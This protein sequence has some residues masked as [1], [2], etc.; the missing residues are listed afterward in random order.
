[1][2]PAQ[3]LS[4]DIPEDTASDDALADLRS[5]AGAAN[6]NEKTLLATDYLNHFNDF[7]MVLDLIPDMP[8]CLEDA[9]AWQ[10][11]NYQDHFRDSAFSAKQLAIEAYEHSPAEYRDQFES[12]VDMINAMI[13]KG[14]ERI[15]SAVDEGN[16]DR[17]GFECA[18][19]S[20]SLQKLMDLISA[21]INGEN[22]IIDQRGIDEMLEN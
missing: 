4:P 20:Q 12:L 19:T 8:D 3:N 7:V 22:P 13:P 10:P 6:I 17:I 5:R 15:R 11:K 18:Q 9:A 2:K 16:I 21:V 14:L 1:M